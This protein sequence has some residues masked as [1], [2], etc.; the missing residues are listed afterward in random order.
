MTQVGGLAHS[1]T[2]FDSRR[3]TVPNHS[4]IIAANLTDAR[5]TV[6]S[7][8]EARYA[9]ARGP[10]DDDDVAVHEQALTELLEEWDSAAA[11][12][13]PLALDERRA[14]GDVPLAPPVQRTARRSD[15][16]EENRR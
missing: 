13:M 6:V 5:Q 3:F 15:P 14:T 7:D 8:P 9:S 12:A 1:R 11:A 16:T 10:Q 2:V 4:E